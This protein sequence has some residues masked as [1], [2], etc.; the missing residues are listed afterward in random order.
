MPIVNDQWVPLEVAERKV[1][2]LA[3]AKR[4][5]VHKAKNQNTELFEEIRDDWRA[6]MGLEGP[7]AG[8][9]T[10]S[11]AFER[12]VE[13]FGFVNAIRALKSISAH[14]KKLDDAYWTNRRGKKKSA[15]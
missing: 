11:K 8:A 7:G 9:R 2:D 5:P 10:D 6:T 15:V 12:C 13:H 3:D 14:A 1:D 4:A